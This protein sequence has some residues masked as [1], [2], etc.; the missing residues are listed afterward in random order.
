MGNNMP[1][2]TDQNTSASLSDFECESNASAVEAT[3]K[4]SIARGL[5]ELKTLDKRI[6]EAI[7][8]NTH[9][10]VTASIKGRHSHEIDEG[11]CSRV[12]AL[13][14]RRRQIK[15]AITASNATHYVEI[16][17]GRTSIGGSSVRRSSAR[18]QR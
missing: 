11:I 13:T 1:A 14:E 6:R 12:E 2:T 17:T 16:G 5:K 18:G 4:M 3:Q 7:T 9:R 10:V 15:A 8:K